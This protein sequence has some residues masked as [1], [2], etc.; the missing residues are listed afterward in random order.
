MESKIVLVP[1]R[2][3]ELKL[4]RQQKAFIKQFFCKENLMYACIPLW[5]PVNFNNVDEAKKEIIKVTVQT[6]DFDEEEK[7]F[8]C[9][10]KIETKNAEQ[11]CK[12]PF[13]KLLNDNT[14]L[15]KELWNKDQ[16]NFN[17]DFFPLDIKI[18]RLG[19]C[20]SP[21]P[22]IYEL[23]SPVWKKIK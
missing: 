15:I 1:H 17:D 19:I 2:D 4:I 20:T 18:F 11:L 8:F 7:L 16:S 9:P 23:S 6:L 13:V 14:S 5:I 10:V 12:L 3:L 21:K 22:G